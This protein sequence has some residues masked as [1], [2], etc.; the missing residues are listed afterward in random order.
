[1]LLLTVGVVAIVIFII[2]SLQFGLWPALTLAL[3]SALILLPRRLTNNSAVQNAGLAGSEPELYTYSLVLIAAAVFLIANRASPIPRHFIPFAVLASIGALTLWQ[4]SSYIQAG[5]LQ[6][7]LGFLA[8]SLGS[9][10]S[11]LSMP[12]S[13]FEKVLGLSI[14]VIISIQTV[15]CLAQLAGLPIFA[16]E[17]STAALMGSRV[18][19]TMNHPNNLGKVLLFLIIL[20]TPLMRSEVRQIRRISLAGVLLA[21]VPM[22]LTGGRATFIAALI[23]VILTGL[24]SRGV[25]GRFAVPIGVLLLVLP[26][27]DSMWQRFE[28]DPEGGSRGYLT[29]IALNQIALHPWIG[30][31]PNSY[32]S[33]VGLSDALT[34]SGLPVHN[35]FLLATA[36]LGIPIATALFLPL[37]GILV[38]AW[39]ARSSF[40]QIGAHARTYV[41]AAPAWLLVAATGWGMLSGSIFPLWMFTLG[42][43][44]GPL[45]KTISATAPANNYSAAKLQPDFRNTSGYLK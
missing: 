37:F 20:L 3:L 43:I 21:F 44:A 35:T 26:F 14:V 28:D 18:N 16:L 7:A 8:W 25:K 6:L 36:E 4:S 38:T 19:G 34:A 11:R 22:A 40:G 23:V 29:D 27:I 41:A 5:L 33:V 2:I 10:V 9:H 1:M 32:V 42:F 24:L 13:S 12:G 39:R 17:E 30:I 45:R 15:V 31:G